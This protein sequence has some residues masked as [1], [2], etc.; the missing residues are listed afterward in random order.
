MISGSAVGDGGVS[1]P[2]YVSSGAYVA[3]GVLVATVP[4]T[5]IDLNP[6]TAFGL[7]VT[8]GVLT[9]NIGQTGGTWELT[10]GVIAGRSLESPRRV[11]LDVVGAIPE[12][13]HLHDFVHLPG[14]QDGHL[15]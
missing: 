10:N 12:S 8:N 6:G 4:Q 7:T 11:Q 2:L 15:R 9:A 3:G 14:A 13:V 5:K 1:D